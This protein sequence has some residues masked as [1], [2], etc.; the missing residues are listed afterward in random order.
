M[1]DLRNHLLAT[2][3]ALQDAEKPMEVERAM[4]INHTAQTLINSATVEVDFI[5][6]TGLQPTGRFF[7]MLTD[8][9]K[10]NGKATRQ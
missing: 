5:E 3:E 9:G 8:G 1:D 4:A 2:L 10:P 7:P 6:A